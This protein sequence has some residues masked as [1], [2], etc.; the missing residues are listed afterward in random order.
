MLPKEIAECLMLVEEKLDEAVADR[1]SQRAAVTEAAGALPAIQAYIRSS[2]K[3]VSV[4]M[5]VCE[6]ILFKDEWWK[7]FAAHD[8]VTFLETAYAIRK[9][10]CALKP[11]LTQI[12]EQTRSEA[13]RAD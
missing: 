13:P 7:E 9:G 10:L 4:A 5:L 1:N 12:V 2:E 3:Q 11:A 8:R 6:Q